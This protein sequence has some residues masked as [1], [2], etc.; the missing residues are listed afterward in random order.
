MIVCQ[1][2]GFI[3]IP[4]NAGEAIRHAL[5]E[6][7]RRCF[8]VS[9]IQSKYADVR[10]KVNQY[11]PHW[12]M[13]LEDA[14]LTAFRSLTL[15]AVVRNPWERYVSWYLWHR[16]KLR[17]C[18]SFTEFLDVVIGDAP[19]RRGS[20]LPPNPATQSEY[21]YSGLALEVLKFENLAQNW[22]RFCVKH[23]DG[24]VLHLNRRNRSQD[25]PYDYTEFYTLQDMQRVYDLE[26]RVISEYGYK[27]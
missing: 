22:E 1:N 27:F 5:F 15:F 23:F 19:S 14:Q 8:K 26:E 17:S 11:Q 16:L 25:T 24:D 13:S 12:L 2:V 7:G 6:S 21:L 10:D 20:Q 4:K 3:H 18:R 9:P